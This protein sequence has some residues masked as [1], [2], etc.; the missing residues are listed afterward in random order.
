MFPL[1]APASARS[2]YH[3]RILLNTQERAFLSY[4][5]FHRHMTQFVP[6][7]YMQQC[8]RTDARVVQAED[9]EWVSTPGACAVCVVSQLRLL[10]P[11]LTCHL[12]I[13][14]V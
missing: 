12:L 10:L 13:T 9:G 8:Q 5:T 3:V 2:S 1:A 6:V 11:L 4:D 7:D 14:C